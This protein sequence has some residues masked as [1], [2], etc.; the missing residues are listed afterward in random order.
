MLRWVRT[1][2]ILQQHQP[3]H[4]TGICYWKQV[5]IYIQI[6]S[7]LHRHPPSLLQQSIHLSFIY[8][9]LSP[10]AHSGFLLLFADYPF[11]VAANVLLLSSRFLYFSRRNALGEGLQNLKLLYTGVILEF[12]WYSHRSLTFLISKCLNYF[13]WSLQYVANDIFFIPVQIDRFNVC[14]F[15]LKINSIAKKI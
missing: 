7:P 5:L 10:S 12:S 3:H 6:H 1:R 13:R 4:H 14:P 15:T 9:Y 2:C 11:M 8:I